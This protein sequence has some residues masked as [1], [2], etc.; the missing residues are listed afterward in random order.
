V[1]APAGLLFVEGFFRLI[2][3][4]LPIAPENLQSFQ[5]ALLPKHV[6]DYQLLLFF[7][8]LPGVFEELLFRGVL[9]HGL[10]RRFHPAALSVINGAVFG[11]FH[12]ALFRLAPTAL[13]GALLAAV[14]LLTGSIFPAMLWHALNNALGIM[15]AR[16]LPGT[17]A[18]PVSTY[19]AGAG[20]LAASFWVLWRN[21]T[22][23]S[24]MKKSSARRSTQ[25]PGV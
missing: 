2:S 7:S 15:A 18:L 14:T 12:V 3:L 23:Y 10:R 5:R 11:L 19:L 8:L 4:V 9:L 20:I 1:A 17:D 6:P 16:Y 24:D 13:L 22:P 21:R 25:K